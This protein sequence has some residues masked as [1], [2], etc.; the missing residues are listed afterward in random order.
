MRTPVDARLREEAERFAFRFGC[1]DCAHFGA[2]RGTCAHGYPT[3]AHRRTRLGGPFLVFCK[4][5]ELGAGPEPDGAGSVG[6]EP[7]RP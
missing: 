1:E 6:E 5:F 3:E 2:E 7:E 4:E